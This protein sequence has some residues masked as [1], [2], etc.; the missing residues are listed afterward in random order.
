MR[1]HFEASA[2]GAVVAT[3]RVKCGQIE[4][5][6]KVV[7]FVR[8]YVAAVDVDGFLDLRPLT[9]RLANGYRAL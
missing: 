7:R 4:V 2:S 5:R 6:H 3:A 9:Q 8:G 1:Y